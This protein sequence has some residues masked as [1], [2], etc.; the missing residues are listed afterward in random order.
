MRTKR[1]L[2]ICFFA[3]IL[4]L[5]NAVDFQP[6]IVSSNEPFENVT[7]IFMNQSRDIVATESFTGVTTQTSEVYYFRNFT[8]PRYDYEYNISVS[9]DGGDFEQETPTYLGRGDI[10]TDTGYGIWKNETDVIIGYV[11]GL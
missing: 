1:I 10:V 8:H 9:F 7:L 11:G 6:V 4:S 2:L 3:S 5:V